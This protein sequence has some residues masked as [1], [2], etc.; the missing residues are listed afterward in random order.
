MLDNKFRRIFLVFYIM[1]TYQEFFDKAKK[2]E[3]ST[4]LRFSFV[5]YLIEIFNVP[6]KALTEVMFMKVINTDSTWKERY[7]IHSLIRQ[8]DLAFYGFFHNSI[9]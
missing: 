9:I 2:A 6:S 4:K 7:V 5:A 3:D 8:S 1:D